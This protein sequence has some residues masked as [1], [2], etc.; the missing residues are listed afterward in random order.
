MENDFS[1]SIKNLV[2]ANKDINREVNEELSHIAGLLNVSFF[3]HRFYSFDGHL[4]Y[5]TNNIDW[6]EYRAQGLPWLTKA[7]LHEIN[8]LN[9]KQYFNFVWDESYKKSDPIYKALHD[10]DMGCGVSVYEK[11][12]TGFGIWG[13][14][15]PQNDSS[16]S[17]Y[18]NNISTLAKWISRFKAS[19][20]QKAG[21][22]P[23]CRL[24]LPESERVSLFSLQREQNPLEGRPH[25]STLIVSFFSQDVKLTSKE[26]DCLVLLAR[27]LSAKEIALQLKMSPRTAEAHIVKIKM[28]AGYRYTH[29]LLQSFLSSP[30]NRALVWSEI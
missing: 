13:F 1:A 3:V 9:A 12:S 28:K 14:S 22:K 6:L 4:T 11:T 25:F 2:N 26:F 19:R 16:M 23:S 27:G 24:F 8:M 21:I 29:D 7:T 20:Q 17:L 15:Q 18:L 10:W 30:L 5:L